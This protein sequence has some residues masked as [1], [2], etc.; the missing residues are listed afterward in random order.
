MIF[1]EITQSTFSE[2]VTAVTLVIQKK[3]TITIS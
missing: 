2:K 1:T 3:I